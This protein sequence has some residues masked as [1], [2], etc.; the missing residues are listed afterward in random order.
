M[1]SIV[2]FRDF[3]ERD[4]DFIH[5]CKNDEKL[6][7]MIVGA[8]R[9]FSHE[10]A[11]KWVQG[12]M[13]EHDS[14]KFWAVCSNDEEKRIIGWVSI[15]EI[16]KDNSSACFHGIVIG[17]KDYRDGRAW[18]ECY[19]FILS[20]VFEVY[21]LNRIWGRYLEDH[22]SSRYIAE[23]VL[24]KKEG[25]FREAVFK[26]GIYHNMIQNSM[27]AREYFEYRDSGDLEYSKVFRRLL[28]LIR[29]SKKNKN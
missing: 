20:Q 3:E 12:C 6:N 24:L 29:S 22:P 23:A 21:K 18:I 10:D 25:L 11:E 9:P 8:F 27:L 19:L 13:G 26:N 1:D 16:S 2:S 28:G 7:S 4:I 15:S 5:K 17:D 14:F